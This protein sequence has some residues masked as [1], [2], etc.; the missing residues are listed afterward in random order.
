MPRKKNKQVK[1]VE[2]K[3]L[4][5]KDLKSISREDFKS[6]WRKHLKYYAAIFFLFSIFVLY[7]RYKSHKAYNSNCNACFTY[8]GAFF[9][10]QGYGEKRGEVLLSDETRVW[11]KVK[12]SDIVIKCKQRCWKTYGEEACSEYGF[13]YPLTFMERLFE[14]RNSENVVD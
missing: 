3:P 2:E 4:W 11:N 1:K 14:E 10:N 6:L 13:E 9:D 12:T 7:G 8:C 5:R